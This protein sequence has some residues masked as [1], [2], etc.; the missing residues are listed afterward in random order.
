[1]E[2]QSPFYIDKTLNP[3]YSQEETAASVKPKRRGFLIGLIILIIL[4]S[5]AVGTILATRIWDP[6]WSPF[7]PSPEKVLL[8]A[9]NAQNN[10]KTWHQ[11]AHVSFSAEEGSQDSF[12]MELDIE[13]DTDATSKESLKSQA[14]FDI[15]IYE[16]PFKFPITGEAKIIEE[17]SYLKIDSF[18]LSALL[19]SQ[20]RRSPSSDIKTYNP[21]EEMR[22]SIL[23]ALADKIMG[24]WIRISPKD[25]GM[26]FSLPREKKQKLEESI[27]KL[28]FKYPLLKAKK[29]F[30]D[31]IVNNNKTYH[32]LL[33]LDKENFKLFLGDLL[34]TTQDSGIFPTKEEMRLTE[35][36]KAEMIESIDKFFD[37][38]GDIETEIWIDKKT[39]FIYKIRG[40]KLIDASKI[41]E[42]KKD[43]QG[44]IKIIWDISLSKFNQP[45]EISAPKDFTSIIEIFGPLFGSIFDGTASF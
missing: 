24:K 4:L 31:E 7:R 16:G 28:V 18:P 6:L 37:V 41:T 1:M 8:N 3:N 33:S 36:R 10:I 43:M 26:E 11:K 22:E 32:Y 27:E 30:S 20:L 2:N 21:Y 35:G 45:V 14:K 39:Y 17:D 5:L 38:A 29:E 40:E 12:G 42:T 44:Y 23:Q 15:G 9:F 25:L 34:K 19:T 13:G